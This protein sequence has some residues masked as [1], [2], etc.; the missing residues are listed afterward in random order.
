MSDFDYVILGGGCA[1]LSLAY[2][3]DVRG[4]LDRKTM[5]VVEPR[6]QY[7]RDKTWSFWRT[8]PHRFDDCVVKRW[9]TFNVCGPT[10]L[11][12][13]DC[14]D[15]PYETIDSGLFYERVLARLS[16]NPNVHFTNHY[17]NGDDNE[18]VIFNSVPNMPDDQNLWQHFK[19]IEVSA[20]AGTFDPSTVTLMDFDCE[21]RGQVHFFYVLPFTDRKALVETTWVGPLG[22][23]TDDYDRQ[24]TEYINAA[25]GNLSYEVEYE[26]QGA[27]PLFLSKPS[28]RRNTIDIGGAGG[29]IRQSTG[30]AFLNIQAH[31]RYLCD[32]VEQL[33]TLAQY[34]IK[35]RYRM[36]DRIF[37]RVLQRSPEL[38]PEVFQRFFETKP[39]QVIPFLSNCGTFRGDLGA[40]MAMPKL[41]FLRAAMGF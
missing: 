31:S 20:P 6:E 38:M 9:S 29:M 21:Q 39:T 3:F 15:T 37:L 17:E 16:R 30:Y 28:N 10:G 8:G 1:G 36:L 32:H 26:E 12:Q 23:G 11:Q 19:G 7:L 4:V 13:V 40:I 27:I 24:I 41:P 2:E 25:F 22:S 18:T 33:P 14:A 34:R 5:L 35:G